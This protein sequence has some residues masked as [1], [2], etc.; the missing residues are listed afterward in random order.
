MST[1][2][3]T[4]AEEHSLHRS[5]IA[6]GKLRH[7]DIKELRVS[8]S[9]FIVPALHH[10]RTRRRP[11]L[12]SSFLWTAKGTILVTQEL[13]ASISSFVKTAIVAKQRPHCDVYGFP[14]IVSPT[15]M[16]T[17]VSPALSPLLRFWDELLLPLPP[18]H[19]A[20]RTIP[21]RGI[22]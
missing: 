17:E 18:S 9:D 2:A 11:L 12:A 4:S 20:L 6:N 21:Q 14:V 13:E 10:K 22:E 15:W 3:Y 1:N 5:A 19:A 8:D 16:H 7:F